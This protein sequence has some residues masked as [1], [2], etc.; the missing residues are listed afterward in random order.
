MTF[1]DS[2][3]WIMRFHQQ[4]RRNGDL[5]RQKL[6]PL[7][8]RAWEML[9]ANPNQAI[10]ILS[11]GRALAEALGEKEWALFYGHWICGALTSYL[12]DFAA[13]LDIA[14]RNAV[15]ARKAEYRQW[16]FLSR[17]YRA[18]ID[19]YITMD[20]VGYADTIHEAMDYL[21]TQVPLDID[22]WRML[23]EQRAYLA[24][25]LDCPDEAVMLAQ[26]S[27]ERNENSDFR[28]ARICKLMCSLN[29]GNGEL[30][31]LLKYALLGEFH[32]RQ[33]VNSK[34][35]LAV[36]LV[37]QAYCARKAGDEPTARRHYGSALASMNY[38]ERVGSE[39]YFD[40]LCAYNEAGGELT[41][42][43]G[44]RDRELTEAINGGSPYQEC[45]SR[46]KRCRVLKQMGLL[47]ADDLAQAR[48][49]AQK[50]IAPAS[51]LAKL[52]AV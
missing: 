48:A 11:E 47:T 18:L 42:A 23:M 37:W 13:G 44:V 16:P 39:D 5:E 4:A 19:G 52:D 21:E 35:P 46:L 12:R 34:L 15:E 36:A 14:V 32:A 29:Y 2:W 33:A 9:E 50:L 3:D 28:M 7:Y 31:E 22:V 40:A 45:E 27:I 30:G 25:T 20:P 8:N 51:F 43:L 17:I 41:Q 24:L 6:M 38:L 10:A 49:A 1:V 26:R